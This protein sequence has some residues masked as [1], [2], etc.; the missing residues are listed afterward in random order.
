MTNKNG[1]AKITEA[2]KMK[3]EFAAKLVPMTTAGISAET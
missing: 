3:S 2:G 1:L